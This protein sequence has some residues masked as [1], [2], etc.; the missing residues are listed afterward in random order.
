MRNLS[1]WIAAGACAAG[2]LA[3]AAASAHGGPRVGIDF[4]V[5]GPFWWGPPAWYYRPYPPV[6]VEEQSA[7]VIVQPNAPQPYSWYYCRDSQMYYPYA[8]ECPSGWQAVTPMPP[9]PSAVPP[10]SR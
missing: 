4:W 9:P 2:L 1:K 3:C 6:V 8:K 5:G 7:P 10:A